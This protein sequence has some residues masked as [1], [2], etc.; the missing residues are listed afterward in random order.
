MTPTSRVGKTKPV[1]D[2]GLMTEVTENQRYAILEYIALPGRPEAWVGGG[3]G[4]GG[5]PEP[6]CRH[7]S[8]RD[9]EATLKDLARGLGAATLC[10]PALTVARCPLARPPQSP[11]RRAGPRTSVPTLSAVQG[12]ASKCGRLRPCACET[13]PSRP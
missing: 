5:W 12:W 9:Y 1:L 3:R 4:G 10:P 11:A 2:Y 8:A 6:P 13:P 7:L